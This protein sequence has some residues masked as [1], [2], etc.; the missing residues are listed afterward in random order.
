MYKFLIIGLVFMGLLPAQETHGQGFHL[1]LNIAPNTAFADAREFSHQRDG[2]LAHFGYG[3]IFDAL[4]TETYAFGTGVNIF[5]TGGRVVYFE[6]S[7]A[8]DVTS[9]RRVQLDQKLQYVEIPLTFK[10]RT[11]EIGYTTYYGQFGVGLG[12]NV[13]A[14]GTRV[15]SEFA[16]QDSSGLQLEPTPLNPGDATLVSLVDQTLL[17]RPSL[18]VGLGM[19]RRFTGTTAL[20]L[21]LRYNN[22]LRNQY[23]AF[24]ILQSASSED[25]LLTID[26]ATNVEVPVAGQMKGKTGQI[27]L[28]IGLMF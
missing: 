25:L 1:G 11:K 4:F 18:I 9:I 22:A 6:G 12:L 7:N 20:A 16:V 10:M 21:G 3:F 28:C 19:E 14:E 13:R 23:Q 8:D 5:Y 17:F 24:P 2:A 15:A 27:E 26:E